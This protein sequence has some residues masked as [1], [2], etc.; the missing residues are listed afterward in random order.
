M[1]TSTIYTKQQIRDMM[2]KENSRLEFHKPKHVK[3]QKWNNYLQVFIDGIG[4]HFISCT[5]CHC[6]LAWKSNDGTNVM[7]KHDKACKQH[8]P[9]AS[10]QQSIKSFYSTNTN[11]NKQLINSTKR[12]IA[13]SLAECCA[14]DNLP[15][16]IVK[17]VG[18]KAFTGNLLKISRQLGSSV[19]IDEILPDSTT[20]N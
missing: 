9:S 12:K 11:V 7:D 17:G 3:S 5:K 6:I 15:F 8:L 10:T 4:Q 14:T 1:V 16:D 13:D 20:L 2:Q 19:S 18:F